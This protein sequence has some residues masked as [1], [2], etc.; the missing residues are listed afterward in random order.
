MKAFYFASMEEK[1]EA[2]KKQEADMKKMQ[3]NSKG[4][5]K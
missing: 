1:V 3:Q 2:E 5:R 4:R